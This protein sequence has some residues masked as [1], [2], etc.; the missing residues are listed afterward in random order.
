MSVEFM[1]L[2][3]FSHERLDQSQEE[4]DPETS[5]GDICLA[6][7]E[8]ESHSEAPFTK[9]RTLPLVSEVTNFPLLENPVIWG[10]WL[11]RR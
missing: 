10:R 1:A 7:D 2:P 4:W 11:E 5:G 3:S 8:M 6:S 9:G